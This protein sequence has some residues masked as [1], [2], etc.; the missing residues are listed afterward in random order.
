MATISLAEALAPSV[1]GFEA[2]LRDTHPDVASALQ[3]RVAFRGVLDLDAYAFAPGAPPKRVRA[4]LYHYDFTRVSSE[5]ARR[6]PGVSMQPANCSILGPY[7]HGLQDMWS[8][9]LSSLPFASLVASSIGIST[10]R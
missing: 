4:T 2:R 7:A 10:I 3:A 5:W 8:S 9:L 1:T 6:T